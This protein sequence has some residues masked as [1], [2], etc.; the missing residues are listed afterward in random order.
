MPQPVKF[1]IHTKCCE[2]HWEFGVN[3]RGEPILFCE[4]CGQPSG[5]FVKL[6]LPGAKDFQAASGTTNCIHTPCC[7]DHWEIVVGQDGLALLRCVKCL[8]CLTQVQVTLDTRG[9]PTK[10]AQC[11]ADGKTCGYENN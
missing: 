7:K 5:P 2:G 6:S 9:L 10:C 1:V 4:K 8:Q 11:G 3:D